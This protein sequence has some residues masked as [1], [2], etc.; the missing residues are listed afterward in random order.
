MSESL[1]YRCNNCGTV[2]DG[3]EFTLDCDSC[4]SSDIEIAKE[5]TQKNQ[6]GRPSR[7]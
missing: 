2:W 5:L 4:S 7:R 3:D 1:K 6:K